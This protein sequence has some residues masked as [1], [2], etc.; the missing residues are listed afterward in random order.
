MFWFRGEFDSWDLFVGGKVDRKMGN[1]NMK[2]LGKDIFLIR[3][4]D[5]ERFEISA[6]L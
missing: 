1:I 6:K 3:Y 5:L 2:N 4:Y